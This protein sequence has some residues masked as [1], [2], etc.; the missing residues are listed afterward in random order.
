MGSGAGAAGERGWDTVVSGLII[1][2]RVPRGQRLR[3][4]G[5]PRPVVN[6]PARRY[7]QAAARIFWDAAARLPRSYGRRRT[8]E[9]VVLSENATTTAKVSCR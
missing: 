1:S 8:H 3:V 7:A 9:S 5:E 6:L 2:T 4:A